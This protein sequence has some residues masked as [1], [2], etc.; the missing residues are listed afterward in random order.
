MWLSLMLNEQIVAKVEMRFST[1]SFLLRTAEV[2]EPDLLPPGIRV[3]MQINPVIDFGTAFSYW[4][5]GRQIPDYREGLD[6]LLIQVYELEAYR[7]GRMYHTQHTAAALSYYISGFDRYY[8]TPERTESICYALESVHFPTLFMFPPCTEE[9]AGEIRHKKT[10]CNMPGRF[11]AS[12]DFTIPSGCLSWWEWRGNRK[13]LVQKPGKK[14]LSRYLDVIRPRFP[15]MEEAGVIR[16]DFTR[17]EDD[18]LWLSNLIPYFKQGRGI[19]E[20]AAEFLQKIPGSCEVLN[21]LREC[22]NAAVKCGA[23][24][25]WNEMGISY[26]SYRAEPV[27]IL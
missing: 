8:L 5:N 1:T 26:G 21:V 2:V 15:S 27:V 23:M 18:I 11:A 22:E 4:L 14:A 24:I 16:F 13:Y 9:I 10:L 20:Q 25:A 6:E 12:P 7:M 19:W 3:P 17:I